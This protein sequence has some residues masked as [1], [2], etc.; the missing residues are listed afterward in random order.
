MTTIILFLDILS[1][2]LALI[3]AVR[4]WLV[5][6]SNDG[7]LLMVAEALGD[8]PIGHEVRKALLTF[9]ICLIWFVASMV[10]K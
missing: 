6:R 3:S 5:L 10:S 7:P 4:V 8:D 9:L 2:V 1:C